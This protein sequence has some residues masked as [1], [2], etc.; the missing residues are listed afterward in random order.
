MK[1]FTNTYTTFD[2]YR[3]AGEISLAH[4]TRDELS[5][6]LFGPY[7]LKEADILLITAELRYRSGL[8]RIT[9][10]QAEL[11]QQYAT[12]AAEAKQRR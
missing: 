9:Q 4:F 10:M 5:D 7:D 8:V 1:V 12:D 3:D 6:L 11:V 2:L